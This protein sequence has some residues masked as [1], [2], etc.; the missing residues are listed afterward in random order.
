M[1]EAFRDNDP[2]DC[3]LNAANS[4]L[5]TECAREEENTLYTSTTFMIWLRWLRVI[6]ALLWTGGAAGSIIAALSAK[7]MKRER[8]FIGIASTDKVLPCQVLPCNMMTRQPEM[9]VETAAKTRLLSGP[10]AKPPAET[11][12][13]LDRDG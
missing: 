8:G 5:V 10:G 7:P 13:R 2:T 6:R 9:S 11:G 3:Q 12:R 1:A 4:S